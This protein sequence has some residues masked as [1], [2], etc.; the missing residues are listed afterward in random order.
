MSRY[1]NE[2]L[3]ILSFSDI[4]VI[5]EKAMNELELSVTQLGYSYKIIAHNHGMITQY[6]SH[7]LLTAAATT[8][9]PRVNIVQNFR[10]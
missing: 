7:L 1:I 8:A 9:E 5:G 6:L 10:R 3:L 4:Y 2:E